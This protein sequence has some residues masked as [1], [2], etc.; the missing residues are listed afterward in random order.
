MSLLAYRFG[1]THSRQD[2]SVYPLPP[3]LWVLWL[4]VNHPSSGA[5]LIPLHHRCGLFLG[6]SGC[7]H[8]GSIYP[9]WL[10]HAP[11]QYTYFLTDRM[12]GRDQ[13]DGISHI[14]GCR[15]S[16][17]YY[18]VGIGYMLSVPIPYLLIA[19]H[20]LLRAPFSWALRIH[21]I[22]YTHTGVLRVAPYIL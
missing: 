15:Y 17:R 22:P 5:P 14:P 2:I 10:P 9:S 6:F 18:L 11:P 13:V 7:L 20:A 3:Y 1:H 12:R 8:Q 19:I 16:T 21:S 4:P